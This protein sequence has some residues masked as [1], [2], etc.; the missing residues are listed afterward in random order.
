MYIN[1]IDVG[2]EKYCNLY[3]GCVLFITWEYTILDT[4]NSE[5]SQ[6]ISK[7]IADLSIDL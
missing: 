4:F 7:F 2:A 5:T 6:R 1:T 3:T